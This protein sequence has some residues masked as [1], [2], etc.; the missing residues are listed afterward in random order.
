MAPTIT[1]EA[2][3]EASVHQIGTKEICH[4]IKGCL[5]SPNIYGEI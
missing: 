1:V 2:N 4:C 3:V 5:K